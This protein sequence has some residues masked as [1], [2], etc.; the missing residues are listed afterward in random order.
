MVLLSALLVVSWW[1]VRRLDSIKKIT[2]IECRDVQ[3]EDFDCWR[4]RYTGIVSQASPEQAFSDFRKQY[5]A[6]PFVKTN[7]HQIAHV[8]GRTAS[9]KYPDVSEAYDRGDNFCWSGYYHGVMEGIANSFGVD[10]L[11]ARLNQVCDGTE[12]R[13][14]YSFYHYNCVH[15]LGHGLMVV[16]ENELFKSLDICARL[17]DSWEQESCYGGVY[18]EN[19]MAELNPD[20]STKYLKADEPLYPCTAVEDKFRRSCYMMQTSHALVVVGQDYGKVFELCRGVGQYETTCYQSLGRD[21]SGSTSSDIGRT[22]ALCML[23]PTQPARQNCIIGA[24]KDFISYHYDDKEAKALCK[25][26]E[27]DLVAGCNS[28]ATEYYKTF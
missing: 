5:E 2:I 4:Q 16:Y 25:S 8:I 9:E 3:A 18:M 14:K 23:G 6:V 12:S 20:H 21:A 1:Y 27:Q 13:G 15:G 28:T 10:G 11:L 22:R 19:V 24:V 26:L 17:D 7:C